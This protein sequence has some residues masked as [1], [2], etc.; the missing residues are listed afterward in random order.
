MRR[1]YAGFDTIDVALQGAFPPETI[2]VLKV[3]RDAAADSQEP[4]LVR[5]GPGQ[6]AMHVHPSGLRGGYAVRADTGPLGEV[7]AFKANTNT[8]EWNGFA[9]I[10][11]GAL[12]VYGLQGTRDRLWVRLA[13]MGFV[14]RGHS[15][16]RVDYAMDFLMID[17]ELSLDSFV[18]HPRMKVRPY[19]GEVGGSMDRNQPSAVCRG[20]RLE[21]VTIGKMPGR[22]IIVYDKRREVVEK[23]KLL[24]FRVW[25]IDPHDTS[26]QVW[27]VEVRAGKK[28]LK[29]RWQIRTFD[30]VDHAVGDV[31]L[32]ALVDVRYIGSIQSDSNV[33]RQRL[34]P[35]WEAVAE[36][37]AQDLMEFRAGLLPGQVRDIERQMAIDTYAMLALGN[38]AGW[39]VA[40]GLNDQEIEA[41]LAERVRALVA[42]GINDGRRKFQKSIRRARERLH[43]IA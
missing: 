29:G 24:W 28:E 33:T 12:A 13:D 34:H 35:L 30:D 1:L 8:V 6:V 9:S 42:T 43:F 23:R 7:L 17:F 40:H 31:F 18:A 16:N 39:A 14:V 26:V 15:V 10:R 3:A 37:V 25:G 41:E 5:I 32:Q 4:V 21:S 27:R 20:R 38:L 19:W 36:H 22:Q 11:A 2:E